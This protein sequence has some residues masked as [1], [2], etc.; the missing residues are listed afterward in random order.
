M[1]VRLFYNMSIRAGLFLWYIM[2]VRTGVPWV[3]E[4]VIQL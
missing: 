2:Y 3:L 1:G 4:H